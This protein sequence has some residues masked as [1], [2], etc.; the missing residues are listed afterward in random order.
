M[1]PFKYLASAAIGAAIALVVS[2]S[3]NTRA[4]A[5]LQSATPE[6]R[7]SGVYT[8]KAPDGK[9]EVTVIDTDARDCFCNSVMW[10][11]SPNGEVVLDCGIARRNPRDV[12]QKINAPIVHVSTHLV[13]P[14]QTAEYL[15][16]SLHQAVDY[17]KTARGAAAK[18]STQP[19]SGL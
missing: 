8:M 1:R 18:P 11:I 16:T 15:E 7:H 2:G 10:T 17:L 3:L 5:Q 4:N 19:S 12:Q 14:L 6:Y 13:L 9:T